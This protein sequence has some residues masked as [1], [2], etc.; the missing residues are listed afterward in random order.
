MANMGDLSMDV[1]S[2]RVSGIS[3]W[4]AV[5]GGDVRITSDISGGVGGLWAGGGDCRGER[6][7]LF[8]TL[9]EGFG[10]NLTRADNW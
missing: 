9:R 1:A 7:T 2:S 4:C 8:E 5:L 3:R 6:D 10:R